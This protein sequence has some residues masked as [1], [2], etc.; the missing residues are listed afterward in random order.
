MLNSLVIESTVDRIMREDD[1]IVFSII[2]GEK[3][4]EI[5]R[6]KVSVFGKF[7]ENYNLRKGTELRVCGRLRELNGD[8]FIVAEHFNFKETFNPLLDEI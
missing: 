4:V 2:V 7:A 5:S 8:V 1:S 3:L 6:F